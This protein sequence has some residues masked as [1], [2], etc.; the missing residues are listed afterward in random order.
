L[1]NLNITR[2]DKEVMPVNFYLPPS[3]A[4]LFTGLRGKDISSIG[5]LL[6]NGGGV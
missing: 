2:V 4:F 1:G 3:E 6:T 5:K